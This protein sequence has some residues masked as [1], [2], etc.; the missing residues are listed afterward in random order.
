MTNIHTIESVEAMRARIAELEADVALLRGMPHTHTYPPAEE[1]FFDDL[2]NPV[3]DA[4]R[5]QLWLTKTAYDQYC[6]GEY[7]NSRF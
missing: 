5:L 4:G 1:S 7:A 2:F 6:N 3:K